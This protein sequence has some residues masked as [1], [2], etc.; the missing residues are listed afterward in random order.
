MDKQEK[1]YII[2]DIESQ[3]CLSE[4]V[5]FISWEGFFGVWRLT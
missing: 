1:F 2:S 4:G 5:L 3:L